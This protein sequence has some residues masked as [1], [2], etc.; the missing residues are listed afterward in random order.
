MEGQKTKVTFW[1]TVNW[2]RLIKAEAAL[3]GLSISELV[4]SAVDE[5]LAKHPKEEAK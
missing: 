4:R 2:H 1:A 3:R 5:Y